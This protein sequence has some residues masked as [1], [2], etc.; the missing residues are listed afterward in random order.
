VDDRFTRP[1]FQ[2]FFPRHWRPE[3][4]PARGITARLA[5][6]WRG[7]PIPGEELQDGDR[8]HS[9]RRLPRLRPTTDKPPEIIS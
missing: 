4:L 8:F 1:A 3:I 7:G 9:E 5:D 6:F 2:R